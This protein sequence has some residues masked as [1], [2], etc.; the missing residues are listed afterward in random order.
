MIKEIEV[1]LGKRCFIV[2]DFPSN[3]LR[4]GR[5]NDSR[6]YRPNDEVVIIDKSESHIHQEI[7]LPGIK[8]YTGSISVGDS[9]AIRDGNVLIR[10]TE[11]KGSLLSG[12]IIHAKQKI[13]S[14]NNAS[15]INLDLDLEQITTDDMVYLKQLRDL[16]YVPEYIDVSFVKNVDEIRKCRQMLTEIFGNNVPRIIAKIETKEALDNLTS[17]CREADCIMVARGD[18]VTVANIEEIPYL[19]HRI[20]STCRMLNKPVIV[21]TQML[22]NFADTQIP[23]R[24]ELNDVALAV[25]Q[26]AS[27]IMLSRETSGSSKPLEVIKLAKK[28]IDLEMEKWPQHSIT[29]ENRFPI[30]AIEGVDGSGKTCTS[31]ALTRAMKGHYISTPPK[32]YRPLRP[33]FEKDERSVRARMLFYVGSLWET[34]EEVV[35]ECRKQPVIL[36]RYTLSTMIYHETLLKEDLSS[37]YNYVFPP[38][39][40]INISLDISEKTALIR[41]KEKATKSFDAD[42]ENDRVLQKNLA[43]KFKKYSQYVI[44]TDLLTKDQVVQECIKIINDNF[45]HDKNRAKQIPSVVVK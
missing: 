4:V 38:S 21:A 10:I 20:V 16:G 12:I 29:K 41:L 44:N 18:L 28:I 22:E 13:K 7:P 5:I 8:N 17:V 26:G 45:N 6:E 39:A 37:I 11:R 23:N 1:N 14:N 33:F 15:I 2:P 27:A 30:I 34:W 40:D 19:Q 43:E 3:R 32:D 31:R 42:L 9:L 36:D 25:R 35:Q 24:S